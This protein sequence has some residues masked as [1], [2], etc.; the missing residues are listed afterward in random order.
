MTDHGPKVSSDSEESAIAHVPLAIAQEGERVAAFLDIGTNS[1]RLLLVHFMANGTHS[2]ISQQK[3]IVRLGEDEFIDGFLR[4][5]A[6]RRATLVM[7]KFREMAEAYHADEIVAIATSAT[8]EA[9]NRDDFLRMLRHDAGIEV[10]TISGREEARLIY[11]GVASGMD[12]GDD[13]ALFIDIGGGSTELVI[14]DQSAHQFLDSLKLGAIRLTSLFF[15]PNEDAPVRDDRYLVIQRYVRNSA[16][17]TLQRMKGRSFDRVIGS[18]GTIQNL[19]EMAVRERGEGP[20]DTMTL[21]ELRKLR[22]RLCALDLAARRA[23]P[24]INASR[25]DLIIAG[26]AILETLMEE[27]DLETVVASD[28]GLREGLIVDDIA[29]RHPDALSGASIRDR[30]VLQLG[31]RC[32]FDEAHGRHV[33]RLSQQ[34]F[35]DAAD[36]GLHRLGAPAREIL[37]HAAMLHDIGTFLSYDN[38]QL[39]SYYLI[40]N[41][42]LLGFDQT[43]AATMAAVAR[44]HRKGFPRKKHR[45]YR[46][47]DK[48]AR[49]IV[50]PLAVFLRLAEA[51]DRSHAGLVESASLRRVDGERILLELQS[52]ADCQ[53]ELWGAQGHR[54]AFER[55]FGQRLELE[56]VVASARAAEP[57]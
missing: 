16:V 55:A 37:G 29:R 3:E 4:P 44:F 22:Q 35:D 1:V 48:G 15:M 9:R 57:Q 38:H 28:R 34:I 53:L 50:R 39:H 54:R 33:A 41:A 5:E 32:R 26:A 43:E 36:L 45:E 30:S 19:V 52:Q 31:R 21:L 11:L 56:R 8:R 25:A 20:N 42:D 24:G 6:M 27:L 23:V 47:L 7:R 40:H 49:K 17:R 12:L 2:V 51:L 13:T 46:L 10:R 14:G 18:S